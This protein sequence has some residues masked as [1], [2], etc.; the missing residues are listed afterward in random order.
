VL[1]LL[2]D[3]QMMAFKAL[4]LMVVTYFPNNH[5]DDAMEW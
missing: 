5:D 1:K 4:S 3:D 2:T